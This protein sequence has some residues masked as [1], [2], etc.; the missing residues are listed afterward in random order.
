MLRA[1]SFDG[2]HVRFEVPQKTAL[3]EILERFEGLLIVLCHKS[4]RFL[5]GT[6]VIV[7]GDN[8]SPRA[9]PQEVLEALDYSNAYGFVSNLASQNG[10][11]MLTLGTYLC[12]VIVHVLL[13]MGGLCIFKS[14]FIFI[15]VMRHE[16]LNRNQN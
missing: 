11:K 4:V 16:A 3:A 13:V 8:I 7:F 5:A 14:W 6:G 2:V 12:P 9:N 1:L 10:S 15:G